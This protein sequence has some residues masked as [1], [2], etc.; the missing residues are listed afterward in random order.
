MD[1]L[2][3][4]QTFAAIA[5]QGSLTAAARTLGGSLP[6]V[7]RSLAALEAQLG[8]RLFNRTTRRVALTEDGRRYLERCRHVLSAV[9]EAERAVTGDASAPSGRLTVTAPVLF[10]Q[11]HVAPAISRFLRRHPQVEVNALLLDRV[12]DLLDE[13]ID[14]GIRI[15][16]LKDSS[17]V[18]QPLGSVRRVVVASPGLLRRHG[19]PQHP[20]ELASANCLRFAGGGALGW[21]F[22]EN[23]QS[24]KVTVGGNLRINHVAPLVDACAAGIGFGVFMSYQV[25][26]QLARNTLRIVLDRFEPPAQPIHVVYPQARLLPARAR[27]FIDWIRREL[28]GFKA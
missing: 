25:A 4:M 24:F 9:D 19:V 15:G 7:V 13:G 3:A 18:A 1:K 5:D 16:R 11:L 6:A 20:R 21:T 2:K 26:D 12:V 27:L 22:H 23:G 10:G 8:V 17:L 14:V 28:R